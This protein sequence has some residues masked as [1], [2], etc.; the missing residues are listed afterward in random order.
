ME[1]ASVQARGPAPPPAEAGP[2]TDVED[3]ELVDKDLGRPPRFM[4]NS[5]RINP[6][7][8][9]FLAFTSFSTPS[10][11]NLTRENHLRRFS[12]SF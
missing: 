8:S 9:S 6:F 10:S 5:L 4:R 7:E 12:L 2:V 3:V 1:L 11:K